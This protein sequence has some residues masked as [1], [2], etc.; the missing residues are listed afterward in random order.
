MDQS[1]RSFGGAWRDAPANGVAKRGGIYD[2]CAADR[3]KGGGLPLADS[4][5]E[6]LTES[7]VCVR[8]GPLII[9]MQCAGCAVR[10]QQ[11]GGARL[12]FGDFLLGVNYAYVRT[13]AMSVWLLRSDISLVDVGPVV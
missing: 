9:M 11:C 7:R 2:V 3:S 1:D 5:G 12:G 6:E 4:R 8:S 10:A 13:V